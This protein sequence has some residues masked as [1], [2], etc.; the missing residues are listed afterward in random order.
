MRFHAGFRYEGILRLRITD[1]FGQLVG[2]AVI[3]LGDQDGEALPAQTE[4]LAFGPAPATAVQ[5]FK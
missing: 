5:F 1:L 2:G 4:P 3:S